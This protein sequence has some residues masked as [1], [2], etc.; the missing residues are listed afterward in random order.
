[1]RYRLN[2]SKNLVMQTPKHDHHK[3]AAKA[4]SN[5]IPRWYREAAKKIEAEAQARA[6]ELRRLAK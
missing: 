2:R 4:L 5:W 6:E 3:W 1:M